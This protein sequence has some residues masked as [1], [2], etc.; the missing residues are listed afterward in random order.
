MSQIRMILIAA[1]SGAG[2]NSFMLRA[3]KDF[4]RLKDIVTYTTRP[5]RELEIEGTDYHFITKSEFE[6]KIKSGFF[7][8]WSPVHDS[9][10]GTSRQ[11]LEETWK[12]GLV[13]I[14][15]IDVQGVEKFTHIY[16]DAVSI[17]ILPPSIEEL[18]KRILRRDKTPP[19]N[20]ELR[21]QNAEKEIRMAHLYDYQLVNDD[22]E[23]SYLVFKKILEKLLSFE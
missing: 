4:S 12:Q 5:R 23:K 7:A 9:L 22:F 15:D 21:L 13:A 10:Y 6:D 11:S 14:M 16:P 19:A 1:P 17:F 18:K 3:F 8:E 2:K 20:L